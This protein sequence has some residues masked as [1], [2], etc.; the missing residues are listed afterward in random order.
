MV[1]QASRIGPKAVGE[2]P[3]ADVG[4]AL[5]TYLRTTLGDPA[6]AFASAPSPITG[7]FDTAIYAFALGGADG[8][9]AGPQI[10][11][12]FRDG[13]AEQ[14][15][16]E[17]VAQNAVA[18]QGYPAPRVLLSCEAA[19]VLGGA[20]TVMPRVPGTVMLSRIFGLSMAQM[21]IVLARTQ[22]RLH[23]LNP[24][25]VRR[26]LVQAGFADERESAR[27]RER[28]ECR[29]VGEGDRGDEARR[30]AGRLRVGRNEPSAL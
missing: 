3:R 7:G 21:P 14:A 11:R 16:F 5:I 17:T 8:E 6:L 12:V 24:E 20:F 4:D 23:A 29:C 30:T 27:A 15:R 2:A 19:A 26:A 28:D 1:E 13:G 10:L 25:P 18:A 9:M 22:A